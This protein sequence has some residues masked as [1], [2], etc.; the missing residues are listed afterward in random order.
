MLALRLSTS[1]CSAKDQALF[2]IYSLAFN[3]TDEFVDVDTAAGDI[4][5]EAGTISLWAKLNTMSTS[6]SMVQAR[7]DANNLMNL[8]Y[9][10]SSNQVRFA[11]KGGGNTKTAVLSDAIENDG[12]W[13]HIAVTWNTSADEIKLYLD[14]AEK[15]DN[16]GLT[17]LAS[18]PTTMD[19]ASNTQGTSF[20]NGNLCDCLLYTS[21]SPRDS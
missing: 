8:Q 3:G 14:G 2:N 6:G 18:T 19:I 10:A 12:K 1:L 15:D 21:P 9:H 7:A 4:N 20:F 11:Y 5:V 16:T 17:V 13:H